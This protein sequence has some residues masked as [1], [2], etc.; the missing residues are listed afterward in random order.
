MEVEMANNKANVGLNTMVK[1][2]RMRGNRNRRRQSSGFQLQRALSVASTETDPESDSVAAHTVSSPKQAQ[3]R[4]GIEA[5]RLDDDEKPAAVTP[6][7]SRRSTPTVEGE[8]EDPM[9]SV[10][11]YHHPSPQPSD[12][13]P[14]Q[15]WRESF[16]AA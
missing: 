13:D 12:A 7:T 3:D 2:F 16:A 9:L 15:M 8:V 10:V 11:V 6:R 4:Q 1:V 14:L 5:R